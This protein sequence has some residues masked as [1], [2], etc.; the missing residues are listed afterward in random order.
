MNSTAK[1]QMVVL[2]PNFAFR[3]D[4]VRPVN[5]HTVRGAAIGQDRVVM[6]AQSRAA[7]DSNFS[8]TNSSN[9]DSREVEVTPQT[10]QG[11]GRLICAIKFLII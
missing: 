5:D 6:E 4:H 11:R 7:K 3:L 9:Q 8:M 10:E 1:F 2:R